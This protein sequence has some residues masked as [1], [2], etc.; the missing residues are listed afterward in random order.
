MKAPGDCNPDTAPSDASQILPLKTVWEHFKRG[1]SNLPSVC[2]GVSCPAPAR[3]ALPPAHLHAP[4]HGHTGSFLQQMAG[5][6]NQPASHGTAAST[7]GGSETARFGGG[8]TGG[9]ASN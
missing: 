6:G 7:Q 5:R 9:T 8:S 3:K 4:P 1:K 2:P